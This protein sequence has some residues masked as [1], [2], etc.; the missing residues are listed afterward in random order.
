MK[1]VLLLTVAAATLGLGACNRTKCPAYT[2]AA[3]RVSEPVTASAA[4][5]AER[6]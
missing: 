2:K 3:T 5:P 4:T 1:R 6:Q